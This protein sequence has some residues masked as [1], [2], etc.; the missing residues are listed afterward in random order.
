MSFILWGVKILIKVKMFSLFVISNFSKQNVN[1]AGIDVFIY[2]DSLFQGEEKDYYCHLSN[3][4][5]HYS[6]H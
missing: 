4:I 1:A 6:M 3:A 2:I 5:E